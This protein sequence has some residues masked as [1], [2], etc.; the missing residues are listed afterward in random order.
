MSRRSWLNPHITAVIE[1]EWAQL[2]RSKV[3]IFTTLVPPILLVMSALMLL[4]FTSWLNTADMISNKDVSSFLARSGID[5]VKLGGTDALK[6]ALLSPFIVLFQVIPL[7]VPITIASY[8]I[9]GEKQSRSL[10]AIL[11][12]PIR[13]WE[14]LLGKALAAAMPG[15]LVSWLSFGVFA[16]VARFVVSD[17]LYA[18]LIVGPTWVLTVTILTPL[19]TLLPVGLGIII[20]SRVSDPQSAQQLGSIVILPVI[21]TLVAQVMGAVHVNVSLVLAVAVVLAL[22]DAALV[23]VAIRLFRRETILTTWR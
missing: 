3:I 17:R 5:L 4:L 14:L 10:E 21:G 11:S 13:T 1:N 9:I 6:A 16:S 2:I 12:T 23:L 18:G 15:V 8:T 22:L 20:S 19:F 7:V